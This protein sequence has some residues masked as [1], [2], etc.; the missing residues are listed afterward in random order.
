MRG[1]QIR[2]SD[3]FLEKLC[4]SNEL[5]AVLLSQ[6]VNGMVDMLNNLPINY[7]LQ[8]IQIDSSLI[9]VTNFLGINENIATFKNG[10]SI[11]MVDASKIIGFTF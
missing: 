9:E 11:M 10:N 3:V 6:Q 5:I 2:K 1:I 8:S 4:T 7:P